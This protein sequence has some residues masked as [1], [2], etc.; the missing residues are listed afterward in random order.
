MPRNRGKKSKH[1]SK[2]QRR[3]TR[4][5]SIRA[6]N[7]RDLS[8]EDKKETPVLPKFFYFFHSI[9]VQVFAENVLHFLFIEEVL[10]LSVAITNHELRESWWLGGV[11]R[12]ITFNEK[13]PI[14]INSSSRIQTLR[15]L[16]ISRIKNL[17][18]SVGK[19]RP[20]ANFSR[21]V[22]DILTFCGN[23]IESFW[24]Y[25]W[26]QTLRMDPMQSMKFIVSS[27]IPY[28]SKLK[29]LTITLDS[30]NVEIPGLHELLRHCSSLTTLFLYGISLTS[31]DYEALLSLKP[32]LRVLI[33]VDIREEFSFRSSSNDSCVAT[34]PILRVHC[35]DQLQ[36]ISLCS[37]TDVN[38]EC[39]NF[40]SE[41]CSNLQYLRIDMDDGTPLVTDAAMILL[42]SRCKKL[43]YVD[44]SHQSNLTRA[45][46]DALLEHCP[47]IEFILHKKSAFTSEYALKRNRFLAERKRQCNLQ[48]R[49]PHILKSDFH[50]EKYSY[51]MQRYQYYAD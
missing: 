46:V 41:K 49:D 39:I 48:E 6:W 3:R 28:S 50:Y 20:L 43:R 42:A 37:L 33:L 36:V 2:N 44:I 21:T 7:G 15:N 19:V 51:W 34:L 25:F 45:T 32:Q 31:K 24:M 18:I 38:D 4:A 27:L 40:I 8:M 14:T 9:P 30:Y 11:L 10:I 13:I 23:S 1:K 29:S 12:Y 17:R 35:T 5:S 26:R 47:R 16:N 22:T